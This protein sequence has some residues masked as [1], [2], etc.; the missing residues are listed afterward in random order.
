[1]TSFFAA[2]SQESRLHRFFSLAVPDDKLI[3]S[4]CDDSNPRTQVTLIVTQWVGNTE[5]INAVGSYVA[6]DETAAEIG[7]AVAD[8]WQG[9]GIG[10]LMLE[11]LALIAAAN[12]IRHFWAM[13][14]FENRPMLDV[15]RESGFECRSKTDQGVVEI[16]LSANA[17]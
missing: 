14:M 2:L 5:T 3:S 4:F 15:F 13:T 6:R 16:D 1:M 8:A 11:R 12:G 17:E 7:L 10:T 9:K